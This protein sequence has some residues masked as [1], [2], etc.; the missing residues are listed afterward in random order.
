MKTIYTTALLFFTV[1]LANAQWTTN[2]ADNVKVVNQT[3][4]DVVTVGM[5]TGRTYVVFYTPFNGNYFLRVQLLDDNGNKLWGDTGILLSIRQSGPTTFAFNACVDTSDNLYVGFQY[6]K[7]GVQTAIINMI[8]PV[9]NKFW[10]VA[11]VELGPGLAP[12]P[13]VLSNGNIAVAWN[14]NGI[15]N[16][17]KLNALNGAKAWSPAKI[18][19]DSPASVSRPQ[20]VA[21]ADSTFGIVYQQTFDSLFSN[22]HL[23]EQRF[24]VNGNAIWASPVQ[25]SQYIT[26]NF[27]YYSVF[28]G[29]NVTYVGYFANPPGQNRFDAFVQKINANG[30]LPWGL[31]GSHFADSIPGNPY[32][33]QINIGNPSGST[34]IW[35]VST[36]SDIDQINYG[37]AV[38]KFNNDDGSQLLGD[39]AKIIFPISTN[40]E[41]QV[42]N[43]SFLQ[44]W[45]IVYIL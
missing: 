24:D 43:L 15:I 25:L 5:Q 28:S 36:L 23:F 40:S 45:A 29:S 31:N 26:S 44:W 19:S 35:A 38:Q 2:T 30:T 32:Q 1:T 11:G 3:S 21:T 39:S 42:G 34:R 10:G 6:Q 20:V 22:T 18:I 17:Q 27:N 9:G 7:A 4:T 33:M 41:K 16:F 14:N 37:I 13:A 12:Y 8:S